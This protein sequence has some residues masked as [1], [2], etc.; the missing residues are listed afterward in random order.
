MTLTL[1]ARRLKKLME[2]SHCL[3]GCERVDNG[4]TLVEWMATAFGSCVYDGAF[5]TTLTAPTHW[6]Q[7]SH[8]QWQPFGS[9]CRHWA[10]GSCVSFPSMSLCPARGC[11]DQ[12][13]RRVRFIENF[14]RKSASAL[15]HWFILEWFSGDVTNLIGAFLTNQASTQVESALTRRP[16]LN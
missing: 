6:W 7:V 12:Q 5:P 4:N 16:P 3:G 11:V 2:A 8:G 10:F 9:E 13:P 15:S 14:Q 1:V